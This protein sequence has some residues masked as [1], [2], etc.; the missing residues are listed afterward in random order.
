MVWLD[1]GYWSPKWSTGGLERVLAQLAMGSV[2]ESIWLQRQE[3]WG[4][5]QP[6]GGG[7]I[8]SQISWLSA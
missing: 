2:Y 5:C 1:V 3:S 4:W 8:R 7:G 6:T